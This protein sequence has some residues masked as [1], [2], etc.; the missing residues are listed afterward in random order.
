[1]VQIIKTTPILGNKRNP[2]AV[3][4]KWKILPTFVAVLQMASRGV[5]LHLFLRSGNNRRRETQRLWIFHESS[6]ANQGNLAHDLNGVWGAGAASICRRSC[7]PFGDIIGPLAPPTPY[8]SPLRAGRRCMDVVSCNLSVTFCA[9]VGGRTFLSS[10]TSINI[11][12]LWPS[13][14]T[15][16]PQSLRELPL[17]GKTHRFG[18]QFFALIH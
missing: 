8:P 7:C 1:M 17:L 11:D 13:S 15:V 18:E 2:T 10:L 14:S 6:H 4:K 16:C 5:N 9:A 3:A 12:I